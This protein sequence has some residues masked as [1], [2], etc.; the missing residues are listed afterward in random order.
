MKGGGS[1][2]ILRVDVGTSI[3]QSS[4][5]EQVA[6]SFSGGGGGGGGGGGEGGVCY[7]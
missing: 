5:R 4:T 1:L 7:G 3:H 2:F 6:I